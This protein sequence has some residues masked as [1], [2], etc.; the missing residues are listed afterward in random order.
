MKKDPLDANMLRKMVYQENTYERIG[1]ASWGA[2]LMR[3]SL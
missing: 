1:S 2:E 3:H